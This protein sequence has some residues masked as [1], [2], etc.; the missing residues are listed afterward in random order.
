MKIAITLAR[1]KP[2]EIGSFEHLRIV[3][4]NFRDVYPNWHAFC[5]EVAGCIP[6]SD[7]RKMAASVVRKNF[8]HGFKN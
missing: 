6:T 3:W 4:A 7:V 2:K 8:D 5:L 1:K